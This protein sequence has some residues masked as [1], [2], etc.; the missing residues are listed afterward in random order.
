MAAFKRL[1][2]FGQ[3]LK[4]QIGIGPAH[5]RKCDFEGQAR[6]RRRLEVGRHIP[7]NAQH[8]SKPVRAK[9]RKLFCQFAPHRFAH[10]KS[11]IVTRQCQHV[12]V[13][14]VLGKIAH[15]LRK[16]GTGFHIFRR[17]AKACGH[18]ALANSLHDGSQFA[19]IERP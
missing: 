13:A 14:H 7:Q 11:H 18:I 8:A 12:H 9:Q 15:E 16:V 17:P 1:H 4:R 2:A 19:G 3:R 5:A 10:V 6:V